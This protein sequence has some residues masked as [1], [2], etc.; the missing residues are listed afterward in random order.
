MPMNFEDRPALRTA[1]R[2]TLR[3]VLILVALGTAKLSIAAF[4]AWRLTH[5]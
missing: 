3:G 4:I 2:W 1:K 5:S